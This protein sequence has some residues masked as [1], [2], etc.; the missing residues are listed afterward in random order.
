MAKEQGLAAKI[1]FVGA[2]NHATASLYPNIPLIPEFE[3]IAVCDLVE[4]KARQKAASYGVPQV[5]TDVGE[6]LDQAELAGVCV[7]GPPGNAL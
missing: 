2:G 7:C 5:F 6:M 3:L 1:A 4:E